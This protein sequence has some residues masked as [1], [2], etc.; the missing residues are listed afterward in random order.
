MCKQHFLPLKAQRSLHCKA[1]YPHIP[2]NIIITPFIQNTHY[3]VI[4]QMLPKTNQLSEAYPYSDHSPLHQ[5]LKNNAQ[6]LAQPP[7][8]YPSEFSLPCEGI[9]HLARLQYGLHSALLSY[10]KRLDRVFADTYPESSIAQHSYG[11]LHSTQPHKPTM[12]HNIHSLRAR[13]RK[14]GPDHS[15][16]LGC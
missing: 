14:P 11:R 12:I 16:L 15:L 5:S 13:R 4:I 1:G 6:M 3:T 2:K 10:Q 8:I 7:D 9:V